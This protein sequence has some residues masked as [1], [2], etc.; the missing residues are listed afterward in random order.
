[1]NNL[2]NTSDPIKNINIEKDILGVSNQVNNI[3]NS[4]DF[5][6]YLNVTFYIDLINKFLS[7]QSLDSLINI[8]YETIIKYI[9]F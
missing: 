2:I 6:N 8:I 3:V 1:M 5:Q 7:H 4:Y 9:K